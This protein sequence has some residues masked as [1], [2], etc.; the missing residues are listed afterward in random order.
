VVGGSFQCID[1]VHFRVNREE[2]NSELLFKVSL[3]WDGENA[4]VHF[5]TEHVFGPLG[6]TTVFEE[7]EG[8]VNS[9]LFV[10]ELLQSQADIEGA[11]VQE[12]VAIVMFSTKVWRTG[13]LGTCLSR[14]QRGLYRRRRC[15]WYE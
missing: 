5:L 4:S 1:H 2:I 3:C 6:S 9:L 15:V 8:P 11:G 7:C 12:C 10:V 14:H 13:E